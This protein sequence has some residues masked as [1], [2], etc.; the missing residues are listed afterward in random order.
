MDEL[1]VGEEVAGG[2]IDNGG[3]QV[4]PQRVASEGEDVG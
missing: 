3:D 4:W 1:P 2:G